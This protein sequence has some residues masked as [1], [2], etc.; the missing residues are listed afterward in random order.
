MRILWDGDILLWAEQ[1]PVYVDILLIPVFWYAR[2]VCNVWQYADIC[3]HV[4]S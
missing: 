1:R 4:N 3:C 2:T